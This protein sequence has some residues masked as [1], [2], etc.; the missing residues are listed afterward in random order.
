M[1]SRLFQVIRE[2][3]GLAYSIYTYLSFFKDTGLLEI[4]A[5]VSPKNLLPLLEAV[6]KELRR[7]KAAPVKE[8][9]LAAAKEYVKSSIILNA[10]DSEQRMLRMAKNEINFGHY[11]PLEDIIAG[12]EQV[13]GDEVLELG[14]ELLVADKW[15]MAALGPVPGELPFGNF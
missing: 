9:E 12:V 2:E 11:I 14:R 15:G 1:S 7:C 8:G 6:N 5:G 13:T 10:E 4:C 3:L